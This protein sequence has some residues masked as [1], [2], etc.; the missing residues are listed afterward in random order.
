[1]NVEILLR[2]A[3]KDVMLQSDYTHVFT[4]DAP[5]SDYTAH[6]FVGQ[7]DTNDARGVLVNKATGIIDMVMDNFNYKR[8]NAAKEK[9]WMPRSFNRSLYENAAERFFRNHANN[10]DF[11]LGLIEQDEEKIKRYDP[12]LHACLV[13]WG[14]CRDHD[15]G[16]PQ[17]FYPPRMV[18]WNSTPRMPVPYEHFIRVERKLTMELSRS[19]VE[20]PTVEVCMTFRGRHVRDVKRGV[21]KLTLT[22]NFRG[23]WDNTQRFVT[24]PR[25][26]QYIELFLQE[27]R[28][29]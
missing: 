29:D 25:N 28:L 1:M 4:L 12:L 10:Q 27:I 8:L 23:G 19:T 16:R 20:Y 22:R 14:V 11:I 6:Y 15:T 21:G 18:Q 3:I 2:Q 17:G 5:N 24:D 13:L 7:T 26:N 9:V